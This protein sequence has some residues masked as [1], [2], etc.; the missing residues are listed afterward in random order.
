[1]RSLLLY[2]YHDSRY[3]PSFPTRRS[4]DLVDIPVGQIV[5]EDVADPVAIGD[6]RQ[7][8]AVR[9]PGGVDVLPLVHV[10]QDVDRAVLERSEEHTSELQSPMY[11]V[12]RLLLE[13]KK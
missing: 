3:L 4:S 13:N 9:G 7:R 8:P 1:M 5:Q 2:R 10:P 6:E 12:C 11:L